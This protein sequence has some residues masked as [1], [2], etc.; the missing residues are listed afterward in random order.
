[1]KARSAVRKGFLLAPSILTGL[2]IAC[3]I[4]ALQAI[5]VGDGTSA[6]KFILIACVLDA[7]DG[8]VAR[9][10]GACSQIGAEMDSLADLLTFCAAPAVLLSA[11]HFQERPEMGYLLATIFCLCG[12]FRLARFNLKHDAAAFQG[13]PTT[14]A[15]GMLAVANLATFR[16]SLM[17]Y[18]ALMLLMSFLMVSNVPYWGG[19][20]REP[21]QRS[22]TEGNVTMCIAGLLILG[23]WMFFE[24]TSVIAGLLL[25]TYVFII[26]LNNLRHQFDEHSSPTTAG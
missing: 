22:F 9:R 3:G 16:P 12:A 15:G 23:L 1:M 20:A 11:L 24:F 25:M 6:S 2:V 21:G 5:F 7:L 14:A 26:P 18:A 19:K 17:M 8:R 13:L 4:A 10:I